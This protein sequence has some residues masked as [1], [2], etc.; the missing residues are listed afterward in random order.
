MIRFKDIVLL[1]THEAKSRM[2]EFGEHMVGAFVFGVIYWVLSGFSG[3]L[4]LAIMGVV[5]ALLGGMTPDTLEPADG[6][7]HRSVFHWLVGFLI[8]IPAYLWISADGLLF[9]AGSYCVGYFSH[10]VLDYFT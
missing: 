3:G 5:F 6:P 1:I 8:V 7:D 10:F 4:L 2:P 9:V